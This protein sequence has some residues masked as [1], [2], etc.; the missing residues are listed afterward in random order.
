MVTAKSYTSDSGTSYIGLGNPNI[1]G[2]STTS[3]EPFF[4]YNATMSDGTQS[5]AIVTVLNNLTNTIEVLYTPDITHNIS[6]SMLVKDIVTID[7][8]F[9]SE[10]SW[11]KISDKPFGTIPSGTI[12][13]DTSV[14]MSGDESPYLALDFPIE[15]NSFIDGGIYNITFN[16]NTYENCTCIFDTSYN[17]HIIVDSSQNIV[18][19]DSHPD[20]N[21]MSAVVVV[22]ETSLDGVTC[23]LKVV[24]AEDAIK[25]IDTKYLPD[26]IGGLPA[27]DA[28]ADEGKFLRVVGGVATW[29]SIPN[30]EEA[31]F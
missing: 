7:P 30:A 14:I 31:S 22:S 23:D 10:V 17:S 12:A 2:L 18:V 28:T 19:T 16:S 29:S 4:I 24:L 13:V 11:D 20:V 15:K 1:L 9:I 5:S 27:V 8:K 3:S 25:K 6:M 26:D 21:G